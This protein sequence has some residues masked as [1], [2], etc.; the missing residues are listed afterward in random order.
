MF[1]A[2]GG[3]FLGGVWVAPLFIDG[4]RPA[5]AFLAAGFLLGA[6]LLRSRSE[7]RL[8]M[9]VAAASLGLVCASLRM[10]PFPELPEELVVVRGTVSEVVAESPTVRLGEVTVDGAA[11]R[12][13]LE[14]RVRL[15]PAPRVGDRLELSGRLSRPEELPYGWRARGIV[16]RMSFPE[17]RRVGFRPSPFSFFHASH[18]QIN[19]VIRGS[20]PDPEAGFLSGILLGDRVALSD[21]LKEALNRT[22]TTHLIAVSGFNVAIVIAFVWLL[23]GQVPYRVLLGLSGTVLIGFVLLVGP[24]SS[25]VRAALMGLLI[26]MAKGLGRPAAAGRLLLLAAVLMAAWN[27]WVLRD[28]LG[29][30]LS[31]SA[32][33]GIIWLEPL[34]TPRLARFFPPALAGLLGATLA[35]QIATEPLIVASFG[36]LSLSAVLI[37][38]L[39]IPLIP[40]A[41]LS[42]AAMVAVGLI[43]TSLAQLAAWLVWP[44][45][46]AA[47][48]AIEW[49]SRLPVVEVGSW[50]GWFTAPLYVL[51][52]GITVLWRRRAAPKQ[53]DRAL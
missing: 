42:G 53:A 34:I 44:I 7:K 50:P 39:V 30:L 31:F 27:P 40:L 37:N 17:V 12:G 13:R 45:L 28:D 3:A 24:S 20:L 16:A 10:V 38:A 9:L 48:A 23:R 15:S 46:H 14:A 11:W 21:E 35:A 51:L 33:A 41:M 5:L 47:L 6:L 18:K 1:W 4:F 25:V 43:S 29:F 36:R 2:L 32:T 22:G 26:L 49:G 52:G 8:A 19:G